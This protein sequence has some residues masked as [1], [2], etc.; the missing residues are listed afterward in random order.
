MTYVELHEDDVYCNDKL[1]TH[2]ES[3][4]MAYALVL[5]MAEVTLNQGDGSAVKTLGVGGRESG[6]VVNGE[7]ELVARPDLSIPSAVI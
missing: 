2:A 6:G 5:W 4:M 1:K 3:Q 7:L